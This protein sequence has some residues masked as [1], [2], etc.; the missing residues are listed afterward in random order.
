MISLNQLIE[1][2]ISNGLLS[3]YH[4]NKI[5]VFGSILHSDNPNDID[6]FVEEFNDYNDLIGLKKE[7]EFLTGKSVD[8]V[9][10]KYASPIIVYR[11]KKELKYV[12]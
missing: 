3:K 10:E 8:I 5:G 7:V 2:I 6:L 1:L 11:A 12:A 4:L 9:I